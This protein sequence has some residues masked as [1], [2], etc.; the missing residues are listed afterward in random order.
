[1]HRESSSS[2]ARRTLCARSVTESRYA[3][4][5]SVP[6]EILREV[7]S[8]EESR[9]FASSLSDLWGQASGGASVADQP[10]GA[11]GVWPDAPR[12]AGLQPALD[13]FRAGLRDSDLPR[14]LFLIG[15]P[16]AGKSHA[17]AHVV[18]GLTERNALNDGLAHRTYRYD[19]QSRP[20]VVV[21]DATIGDHANSRGALGH[22]IQDA[23]QTGA[24][25]FACVNRG[26][27]VEE[28]NNATESGLSR[29][30]PD[31]AVIDWLLQ[32]RGTTDAGR[33]NWTVESSDGDSTD[34]LRAGRL[35]NGVIQV[36]QIMAVF[37][38]VCSLFEG[39][40]KA[41]VDQIGEDN[42]NISA[43]QYQIS[44]FRKRPDSQPNEFAAGQLFVS[45]IERLAMGLALKE[46]N[47]EGA[48]ESNVTSLANPT[49]LNGL[50][51]VLRGSEIVSSQKMTYRE[52]W[53]AIVRCVVGDLPDQINASDVE[54]YLD[55]LVPEAADPEAEFTRYMELAS[56]RYS[57]ALYGA[58]AELADSA[59]SLRNPVTRLTQMVDPVRDALPGDN[60]AGTT[61]WATAV[62]DAFA[63][64]VEGGSPL[65]AL[66]DSVH[67]ED[68]FR[69]AVGQFDWKL[70]A[71]FKAVSEK[72][73]L[74][75][76]KRFLFIA[77]YGG[78]LMRLYA[79]ANGVP[80]FRAEIDTWTAAWVLSPKIPDDLESRL[81]T[82]LKPARVQGAPEG[83]SLI[84]IYDSRTN[85][86]TG[87]SRPQL[88]LRTSSIDME[89]E[90]AG[91][92]LFL[93]IKEGAKDIRPVLLDFP[94]VR[95]AMAC[96]EGYSGVTELSDITSPRLER[97]RAARL[98]P[99]DWLDAQRYRVVDGMSD[100]VLSVGA[101]G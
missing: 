11:V 95:E 6:S 16:G 9:S 40:P 83:Y 51:S 77:W 36:A 78:Y 100:E 60:S 22:D 73:D 14:L 59:D 32:S 52:V 18:D 56:G 50:L 21:N 53:G 75:P 42:V 15:G 70:D 92:A 12:P 82:L 7:I 17:A 5:E 49:V 66:F 84:P 4:R 33:D 28:L 19:A 101:V 64:Q 99:G 27:L 97:F 57:Q 81:M 96:G 86:I 79:T 41:S 91:E 1:M 89:T 47:G 29:S 31:R 74:A 68:P 23:L 61:G 37:V 43:Q 20:L 69:L 8:L 93:K 39:A 87:S 38:D 72:Q 71:T 25:F 54:K 13:W 90:S 45:V 67:S 46:S 80:A 94:M 76:D 65:R 44:R 62:S 48:I 10:G 85:P 30:V 58:T 63:G 55:A 24:H 98:V 35:Y 88:A 2:G 26:I 34:Y 3:E